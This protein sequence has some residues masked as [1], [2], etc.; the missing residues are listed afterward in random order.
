MLP[1]AAQITSAVEGQL[2]LEDWHNFGPDYDRTLMAW[3]HNINSRWDDLPAYDERFRRM[4]NFYL[5][6]S[7]GGFRSNYLSLWQ[8]VFSRDGLDATYSPAGIR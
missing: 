6:V 5:L 8:M 4:W 7:A 1:S 2:I 3:H